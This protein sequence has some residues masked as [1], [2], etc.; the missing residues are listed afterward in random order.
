MTISSPL[1]LPA[2]MPLHASELYARNLVELLE[3]L[4][5]AEGRL[6]IDPAD[7]IV[8]GAC[9]AGLPEEVA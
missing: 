3:L 6:A 9:V 7:E 1:N 2:E 8:A 5:D 4:V